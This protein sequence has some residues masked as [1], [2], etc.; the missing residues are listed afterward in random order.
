MFDT[1][2]LMVSLRQRNRLAAMR[3]TQRTALA[4]FIERGFDNVTVGEI[5]EEAGM[6]A[7]TIYR[8][9]STKEAIVIWDENDTQIDA[10][11]ESALK[12]LPPLQ[13]LRTVF[14][15]VLSLRYTEDLEYQ[16]QRI[17]YIYATPQLHAAAVEADLENRTELTKALTH[18]LSKANRNAAAV[19]AGCAL[20][21]LDVAIDQW[22]ASNA[23][24]PL[25][26]HINQAF[27]QLSNLDALGRGVEPGG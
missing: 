6:A 9:F 23:K 18:F 24:Q 7:S 10:E 27:D 19:I 5:A 3:T 4:M 16:L 13:A 11:L 14:V 25:A 1:L 8:H 21:A 17:Q 26:R 12:E 22:Q 15:E 2:T 20:L